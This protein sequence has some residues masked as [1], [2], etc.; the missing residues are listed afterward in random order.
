MRSSPS[1]TVGHGNTYSGTTGP[2]CLL[3]RISFPLEDHLLK[4]HCCPV[5]V[6]L[7]MGDGVLS[8]LENSDLKENSGL[9]FYTYVRLK[10]ELKF[11]QSNTKHMVTNKIVQKNLPT[12]TL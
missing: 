8:T 1:V 4:P 3:A 12:F 2:Q 10:F 11:H 7:I 5:L 9:F 6:M